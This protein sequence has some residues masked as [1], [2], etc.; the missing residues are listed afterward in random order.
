M[1]RERGTVNLESRL[2][3]WIPP[4]AGMTVLVAN[5]LGTHPLGSYLKAILIKWLCT[6]TG[7]GLW[8]PAFAGMTAFVALRWL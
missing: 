2:G 6:L 3:L 4:F 1:V 7:S 5:D 8:I